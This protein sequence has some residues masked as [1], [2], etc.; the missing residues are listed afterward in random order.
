MERENRDDSVSSFGYFGYFRDFVQIYMQ[1]IKICPGFQVPR[2]CECEQEKRKN[3]GKGLPANTSC[4]P[5]QR[6]TH[7]QQVKVEE[8]VVVEERWPW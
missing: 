3:G 4:V 7:E 8:E 5:Q 6:L 2:G 1:T